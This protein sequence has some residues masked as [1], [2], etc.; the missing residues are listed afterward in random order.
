MFLNIFNR[1]KPSYPEYNDIIETRETAVKF[2]IKN[3]YAIVK[4]I[5]SGG[6]G[7]VVAVKK[8]S[9]K[10]IVAAKIMH[11]KRTSPGEVYLWPSLRHPNVLPLHK[12]VCYKNVD[13]F[14][15]P[16]YPLSLYKVLKSPQFRHSPERFEKMLGFMKD[17]ITGL[18]YLHE[19]GVCHLD[20]KADN[21]LI[22]PEWRAVICDFS[23][24]AETKTLVNK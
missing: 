1:R 6:F 16:H 3:N 11:K 9:D 14:F 23:G 22:T 4:D 15:M 20:V 19:Y 24:I 13:I 18:E 8:E 10:K 5:G 21:I 2:F 7:D 17:L 12:R